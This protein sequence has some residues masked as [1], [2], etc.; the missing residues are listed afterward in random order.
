M[1]K[2]RYFTARRRANNPSP[3]P[4]LSDDAERAEK[5]AA[6]AG[7]NEND[8]ENCNRYSNHCSDAKVFFTINLTFYCLV[9]SA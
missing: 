7:K 4:S 5:A 1:K 2:I 3:L 8:N 6:N 9:V